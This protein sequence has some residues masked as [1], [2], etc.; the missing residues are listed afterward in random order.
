MSEM[1]TIF[2]ESEEYRKA[3]SLTR[4]KVTVHELI[5]FDKEPESPVKVSIVVPV[6][7]VEQYLRECLNSCVRQ[8]LKEIE[9]IC[10]NDG[11][12]DGSL[13]ILKEYAEADDRVKVIDKDNAGY[14]H[15]MNIGMDMAKGEYIGIVESDDFVALNMYEELYNVAEENAVDWVKADFYRFVYE[16]D[17]IKKSLIEVAQRAPDLYNIPVDA[18]EDLR[19]FKLVMQTWSGIYKTSFL[20]TNNIRHNETPGASYQDNGFWFQTLVYA[21]KVYFYHKPFY[22]NRRDNPNSSVYNMGKGLRM[23]TEYDLIRDAVL[24]D[25][26]I[27]Q[28]YITMY[29]FK[30]FINYIFTYQALA[31]EYKWEYLLNFR[32]E[33]LLADEKEEIDWSFYDEDVKNDLLLIMKE[34]HEYYAAARERIMADKHKEEIRRLISIEKAGNLDPSFAKL[35]RYADDKDKE[36]GNKQ[37]KIYREWNSAGQRIF[38][39]FTYIPHKIKFRRESK[40]RYKIDLAKNDRVH[41]VFITDENYCMPTAVAI[42]SIKKNRKKKTNYTIHIVANDISQESINNFLYLSDENFEIDIIKARVD[43]LFKNF[44]KGDNDLHVSPSAILKF[45]LPK[46]LKL[47]KVLYIDGDVLVQDDLLELYNMDLGNNYAAVVKDIISVRNPG[48]MRNM[49]IKNRFYFNSGMMLLNLTRIRKA[50]LTEKLVDY[51]LNGR[52]H[53]M[54]QDALNAVFDE[55]VIYTSYRYNY[56]NK[57]HDWWSGEQLS[58][59]YGENIPKNRIAAFK[60]AVIIHLGSHEKPW[61]YKMG[62]LSSLYMKYYKKSPYRNIPLRL[63]DMEEEERLIQVSDKESLTEEQIVEKLTWNRDQRS[64]LMRKVD[65]LESSIGIP[66]YDNVPQDKDELNEQ[67]NELKEQLDTV[68]HEI[69]AIRGSFSFKV[70][71]YITWLP[72]KIR[73]LSKKH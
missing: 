62:Y 40:K 1:N 43:D 68:N 37:R 20:R 10:V 38:R 19:I 32:S 57:F 42:T 66:D 55:N 60:S 7:N 33:L 9:I 26:D 34:P 59:F 54:D 69:D 28:K 53:F 3:A 44:R 56:L 22:M 36:C 23:N 47:G 64:L 8:T 27:Y 21:E 67:L 2:V 24:S 11:S 13:D 63:R 49:K 65:V 5:N 17:K 41:V 48:H 31:D 71:R 16:N 30:K 51:R 72:R 45:Q 35:K 12:S 46:L 18:N 15:A 14:G 73:G 4:E 58:V 25:K 29:S 50:N 61:I 39:F 70:G 6:C 52:N